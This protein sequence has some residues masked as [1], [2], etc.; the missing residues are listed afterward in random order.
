ASGNLLRLIEEVLTLSQ[1]HAGRGTMHVEHIDLA[2]SVREVAELLQPLVEAKRLN[3]VV[4]VPQ[5]PLLFPTD[6][7]KFRQ[8]VTNLTSHAVKF[9][10]MGQVRLSL[11][12][13]EAAVV[14]RVR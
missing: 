9:T 3:L 12:A 1:V 4:D 2:A 8:I 10:S 11:E 7:A 14:L 6:E 5:V 13:D